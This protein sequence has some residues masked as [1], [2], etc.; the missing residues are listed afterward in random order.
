MSIEYAY[1]SGINCSLGPFLL[2]FFPMPYFEVDEK[3]IFNANEIVS[4]GG[5]SEHHSKIYCE[6]E[7]YCIAEM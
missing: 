1:D 2:Y 5:E 3:G 6:E 4:I 7:I